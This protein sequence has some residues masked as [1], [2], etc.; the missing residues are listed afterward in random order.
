MIAI[1]EKQR[2][3]VPTIVHRTP[4]QRLRAI[5]MGLV[6]PIVGRRHLTVPVIVAATITTIANQTVM[7]RVTIVMIVSMHLRS[8][9][10]TTTDVKLL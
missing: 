4:H 3:T 1:L 5:L 6:M 9:V 8:I 10:T 2:L 7:K